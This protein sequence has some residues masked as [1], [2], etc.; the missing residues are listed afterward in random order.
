VREA[1]L[2]DCGH[3]PTWDDPVQVADALLYGSA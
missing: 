1:V 2:R 3:L